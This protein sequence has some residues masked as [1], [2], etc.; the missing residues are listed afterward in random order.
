[1]HSYYCS[2]SPHLRLFKRNFTQEYL[3]LQEVIIIMVSFIFSED[4]F[5]RVPHYCYI[6]L[7]FNF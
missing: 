3:H 6:P 7:Q 1:M 2:K 4:D 5:G